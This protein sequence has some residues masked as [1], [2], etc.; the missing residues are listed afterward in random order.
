MQIYCCADRQLQWL[1]EYRWLVDTLSN[2]DLST[3]VTPIFRHP[4]DIMAQTASSPS[5]SLAHSDRDY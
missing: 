5:F 2:W 1:F 4:A 3:A